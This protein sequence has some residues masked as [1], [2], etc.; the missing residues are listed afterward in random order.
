MSITPV[1]NAFNAGEFS[2]LLEGRA[3][4]QKYG[5]ACRL[6]ENFIIQ[7]YGGATRRPGLKYVVETKDSSKTARLISFEF[8]QIQ[9]YHLEFGDAYIRFIKDGVQIEKTGAPYEIVTPYLEADLPGLKFVQSA[10]V[11]F[12]VHPGHAPRKLSR[13]AHDDWKLELFDFKNGPFLDE[14]ITDVTLTASYPAWVTATAYKIGNHVTVTGVTYISLTDHTSGA[15]NPTPPGNTTDWRRVYQFT[16]NNMILTASANTFVS[17]H[18]GSLWQI[19]HLRTD[20]AKSGSL[21]AS[22]GVESEIFPVFGSWRFT[23]RG[24][25]TATIEIQRSFDNGA[26]WITYQVYTSAADFNTNTTGEEIERNVLYKIK[27]IDAGSNAVAWMFNIESTYYEGTVKITTVTSATAAIATVQ[28]PVGSLNATKLWSE[29][30]WSEHRGYPAVVAFF[31]QRLMFAA[32]ENN[33]QTVWGSKS[34]DFANF[35]PGTLDDDAIN[36]TIG[37]DRVNVI[38]WMQPQTQLLIGTIAG[39]WKMGG[40]DIGEPITPTNVSIRRQSTYGSKDVAAQLVNDVVLFLQ[41]QG[42]KVREMTLDPASVQDKYVAPDMTILAEHITESSVKEIAYQQQPDSILW[43]VR[44]DG[45]LIGMTYERDQDVIGWHRHSTDGKVESISI[46]P[47]ADEDEIAVIVQRLIDGNVVRYI[48]IFAPRNWGADQADCFFVDSGLTFNGGGSKAITGATSAAEIVITAIG[49]G[50]SDGDQVRID[51]VVGMTELNGKVYTVSDKTADT[52]KIKDSAGTAYISAL[53]DL[54]KLDC[55]S[56]WKMN[57]DAANTDV[58][59]D[60]GSNDGTASANTDT[61]AAAGKINGALVFNG[62]DDE[63]NFGDADS[64]QVKDRPTSWSFWVKDLGGDISSG[65]FILNATGGN[66]HGW[67][68]IVRFSSIAWYNMRSFSFFWHRFTL[69]E[70]VELTGWKHICVIRNGLDSKIYLDGVELSLTPSSFPDVDLT[71]T[72]GGS[73]EDVITTSDGGTLSRG[74]VDALMMFNRALTADEVAAIYNAGAGTETFG[75]ADYISGG[76]AQRVENTFTNLAHLEGKTC[77]VLADGG[78]HPDVV[79]EN[80]E[81]VLDFFANKVHIGLPYQSNLQPTKVVMQVQ[82]GTSMA[83]RKRIHEIVLKFYRTLNGFIGRDED[84]LDP[85]I[86]SKFTDPMGFPPALYTGDMRM[87]FNG[88]ITND[89]DIY[90]RQ[91]AP[92]PMT[93]LALALKMEVTE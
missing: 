4:I 35:Q 92:L 85:I 76:T 24:T 58:V 45:A 72:W 15:G 82:G 61:M 89:A 31:E 11:M 53:G 23:T 40:S 22:A 18:V 50:F 55:I 93:V 59:D 71:T 66:N 91:A 2:P 5:S 25:W 44:E 87:P 74:P 36:Y 12:I 63:I 70:W 42:R 33:P 65:R 90:V 34:G 37:A 67:Q 1:I 75:F 30:A 81:A 60:F 20:A 52:F 78:T 80:G 39:E 68:L 41:R 19:R 51:G 17:A 54:S 43:C 21:A 86:F 6:L 83:R 26:T 29:G 88:D 84:N 62:V 14:N 7:P 27:R 47:G 10:D 57:D 48:E 64:L 79:V 77:A 8:N 16:G 49:H 13:L 38:R 46:I 3:D 28:N 9:A 69:Q 56:F 73:D 32:T